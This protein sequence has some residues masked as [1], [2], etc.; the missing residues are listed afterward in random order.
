MRLLIIACLCACV[1]FTQAPSPAGAHPN[2]YANTWGDVV[3]ADDW[4]ADIVWDA[5]SWYGV[6]FDWLM[7]VAACESNFRPETVG[8]YGEI[9]L[10][11]FMPSTFTW[12]A[13]GSGDIWSTADQAFIASWAFSQGLSG[14]WTCAWRV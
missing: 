3:C 9:G 13:G 5:A 12:M 4:I 2:C 7:M 6:D 10:F 11:Q 1:V 8:P 14:H